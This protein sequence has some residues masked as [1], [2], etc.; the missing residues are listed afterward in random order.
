MGWISK[1]KLKLNSDKEVLLVRTPPP[2]AYGIHMKVV[3]EGSALRKDRFA[4]WE[5]C[6]I[7]KCHWIYWLE[8]ILSIE[9]HSE[10]SL[11]VN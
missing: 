2:P 8:F 9:M 11:N 1:I 10:L 6:V 4:I 7:L 5:C 3:Q